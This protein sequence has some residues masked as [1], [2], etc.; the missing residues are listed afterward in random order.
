MKVY[1]IAILFLLVVLKSYAQQPVI[2]S[3][4]Q[5][6]GFS[7]QRIEISGSGFSTSPANLIVR[8][9]AMEGIVLSAT[10]N[11][12]EAQVPIG[13]TLSSIAVTHISSNLTGYS[14]K[15]FF[16]TFSGETTDA[17]SI[18]TRFNFPRKSVV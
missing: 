3:V 4:S 13:A 8:F 10:N 15:D 9:G 17:I 12:I 6:R 16:P 7:G 2:S 11:F 18:S 1:S 14:G 5:I